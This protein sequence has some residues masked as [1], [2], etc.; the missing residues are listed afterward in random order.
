LLAKESQTHGVHQHLGMKAACWCFVK[1]DRIPMEFS[2]EQGLHV[3][4]FGLVLQ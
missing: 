4:G 2:F 3:G 1:F